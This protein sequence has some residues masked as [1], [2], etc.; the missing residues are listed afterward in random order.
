MERLVDTLIWA[1]ILQGLLL[2]L[3]YILSKKHRSLANRL[4]GFFVLAFVLEALTF[5]PLGNIGG[6]S[7]NGYFTLL[8]VKM[9]LPILFLHYVLEKLGRA[10]RYRHVLRIHYVLAFSFILVTIF[11]ISLFAVKGQTIYDVLGFGKVEGVFMFMQYYAFFLTIAAIAISIREILTYSSLVKNT[12]SDL[13][14]LQ[15]KWLWQFVIGVIPIVLVWGAELIRIALGGRGDS[16]FTTIVWLLIIIFIYFLSFRAYQQRNLPGKFSE[17]TK[18]DRKTP[19]SPENS[20]QKD[21]E[22]LGRKLKDFMESS[23]I[24]VRHDLTLYDLSREIDISPRLI[25]TCINRKFGNN[26]AEWVNSFRVE[27]ALEHLKDPAR[28][29]FS[30]EGI[31]ADS[32]FKSRSAMYAAFRK[33]TGHSP[34]HFRKE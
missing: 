34:G 17:S 22:E 10:N 16:T 9:L 28:N 25:S 8:E 1:A 33:Q 13:D 31:G 18:N 7:T 2:G 6:Y 26:F 29:H 5:V 23:K 19:L 14:M 3:L 24:Y 30:V 20:N 12:Y 27:K 15:I 4:L 11:N 32:G 21:Y